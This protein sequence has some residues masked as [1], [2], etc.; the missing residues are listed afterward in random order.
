MH[1]FDK[2]MGVELLEN[3]HKTSLQI[4]EVYENEFVR[5]YD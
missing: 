2:C 5:K 4:K 3:L 1:E